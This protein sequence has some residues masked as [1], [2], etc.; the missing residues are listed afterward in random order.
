MLLVEGNQTD[1]LNFESPCPDDTAVDPEPDTS[2][3]VKMKYN[4]L[5]DGRKLMTIDDVKANEGSC[6]DALDIN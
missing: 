4:I 1:Y 3:C 5:P 2:K 6:T